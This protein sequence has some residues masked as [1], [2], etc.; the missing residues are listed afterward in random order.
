[1]KTQQ[2]QKIL[3]LSAWY[4]NRYDAMS[5]LF[6]RKHA[7]CASKFA[8][9]IVLYPCPIQEKGGNGIVER[10]YNN[11]RE[12]YV[13]YHTGKT[14]LGKAVAYFSAFFRGFQFLENNY[15]RPDMCHVNILTRS[16]VCALVL[17]IL[18]RIPYVVTEHWTR[19]LPEN[20]SYHGF[21]R[22]VCTKVVVLSAKAVSTVSL[23]LEAAMKSR[24]LKNKNYTSLN[25]VVDDFFFTPQQKKLYE[26]KQILLVSCFNEPAKNVCGI[27]RTIKRLSQIRDDFFLTIV[28]EGNDF[29]MAKEYAASLS[30][31]ADVVQFVGEKSPED[32]CAYFY[33][34]DFS[35]LFSNYET[36]SIVVLESLACGK[37]I[38]ATNVGVVPEV[39]TP[40][41]GIIVPPRDEEK[42]L[43][44]VSYMLDT[45]S[46][47]SPETIRESA[48]PYSYDEVAAQLNRLYSF[49]KLSPI[50]FPERKK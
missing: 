48:K 50:S 12:I 15:G 36:A 45:F 33:Q 25:N 34:S 6:V 40:D 23:M 26:R 9:V 39:I 3:F 35:I 4:P 22:K 1:M 37:P 17:Q 31:A 42:F 16:G 18:Y 47:Y 11:V 8:D 5:G 46:N 2:R 49:V 13:Y 32:V 20:N 30:L 27:L 10:V 38:V 28:G 43:Q 14:R 7:D 19:Y 29:A 24:G 41:T 21:V 44:A